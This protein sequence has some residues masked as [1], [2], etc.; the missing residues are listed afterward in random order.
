MAGQ[1]KR[2]FKHGKDYHRFLILS[3]TLKEAHEL[4]PDMD[5]IR[6]SRIGRA[7]ELMCLK[8]YC[9]VILATSTWK[10]HPEAED[11]ISWAIVKGITIVSLEEACNEYHA[12]SL[13]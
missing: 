9:M 2:K 8:R 7:E 1:V 13:Y 11:I 10:D 3:G 6:P 4:F 5:W 12:R